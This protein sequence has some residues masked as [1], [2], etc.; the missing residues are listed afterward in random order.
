MKASDLLPFWVVEMC[1]FVHVT[2]H[3]SDEMQK[4]EKS[5]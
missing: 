5:W 3:Y 2:T 4:K 1:P